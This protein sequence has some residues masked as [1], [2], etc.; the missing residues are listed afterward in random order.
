M[1]HTLSR[2]KTLRTF[3][4]TC[5]TV[6]SVMHIGRPFIPQHIFGFVACHG[7]KKQGEQA[8]WGFTT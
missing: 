5:S 3:S 6:T 4:I 7:Y 8:F 2:T 1:P